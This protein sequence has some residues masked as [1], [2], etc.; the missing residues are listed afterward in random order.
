MIV[1]PRKSAAHVLQG[2]RDQKLQILQNRLLQD[3]RSP[4]AINALQVL[5]G[6]P[7][8]RMMNSIDR[9]YRRDRACSPFRL[10]PLRQRC[11]SAG[12]SSAYW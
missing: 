6:R 2:N 12:S 9:R 7:N 8:A 3:M 4:S 5:H 1:D 10:T 11:A